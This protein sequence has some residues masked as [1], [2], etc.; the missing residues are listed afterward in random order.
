[1][2]CKSVRKYPS[3]LVSTVKKAIDNISTENITILKQHGLENIVKMG[4]EKVIDN[5]INGNDFFMDDFK[6]NI[7]NEIK[8]V[9][10]KIIEYNE[11]NSDRENI[12][13]LDEK[14]AVDYIAEAQIGMILSRISAAQTGRGSTFAA[15]IKSYIDN[16]SLV[17]KGFPE[18]EEHIHK[19]AGI[20]NST[21]KKV[22]EIGEETEAQLSR[23][24]ERNLIGKYKNTKIPIIKGLSRSLVDMVAQSHN[25]L[26]YLFRTS[27]KK[28]DFIDPK[29][30]KLRKKDAI[31][32]TRI[33]YDNMKKLFSEMDD[34]DIIYFTEKNYP[35]ISRE[36]IVNG[37]EKQKT[38][39]IANIKEASTIEDINS[40]Y[41]KMDMPVF[42]LNKFNNYLNNI[43]SILDTQYKNLFDVMSGS[44]K[45]FS[46]LSDMIR[47]T[48]ILHLNYQKEN[49]EISKQ[50]YL[51][52]ITTVKNKNYYKTKEITHYDYL[53]FDQNLSSKDVI[54][55]FSSLA[56]RREG[57]K[58]SDAIV[59]GRFENLKN[60]SNNLVNYS[61]KIASESAA[62]KTAETLGKYISELDPDD[63][64][65]SDNMKNRLKKLITLQKHANMWV[66]SYLHPKTGFVHD[67]ITLLNNFL[68]PSVL[69][70]RMKTIL[71]QFSQKVQMNIVNPEIMKVARNIDKY[72]EKIKNNFFDGNK[73]LIKNYYNY[74]NTLELTFGEQSY[75]KKI[76]GLFRFPHKASYEQ[77]MDS[78]K[79]LSSKTAD[80][81]LRI[82]GKYAGFSTLEEN[83]RK[84]ASTGL[85][86][87]A[88]NDRLQ[89]LK[90][91]GRQPKT[92]AEFNRVFD[93]AAK[94]TR[95][96]VDHMFFSYKDLD[97]NPK[98]KNAPMRMLTLFKLP[99]IGSAHITSN[100]IK[101]IVGKYD[102]NNGQKRLAFA[103]LA[104]TAL[105][106]LLGLNLS[107]YTPIDFMNY[108]KE[109][110]PDLSSEDSFKEQ[111]NWRIKMNVPH[112]SFF[113]SLFVNKE[114]ESIFKNFVVQNNAIVGQIYS[115]AS[116]FE[117]KNKNYT[118]DK[119]LRTLIAGKPM[120]FNPSYTLSARVQENRHAN[121]LNYLEVGRMVRALS[122]H[123][124]YLHDLLSDFHERY[125]ENLG[126]K[127]IGTS[128]PGFW[129]D[130]RDTGDE[131]DV[132]YQ[133]RNHY[134]EAMTGK[135]NV[136]LTVF[137]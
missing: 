120:L 137:E 89:L 52:K 134:Y 95:N 36:F 78:L 55:N 114:D 65:L 135:D 81:M 10:N 67:S 44:N 16:N 63:G 104:M 60:Y 107:R 40:L 82:G 77:V 105:G 62:F 79:Q 4:P 33:M 23:I 76:T 116:A 46:S 123:K 90:D 124:D 131:I 8:D 85:Y 1:M 98:H 28:S 38:N 74:K 37:L 43:Q 21:R 70:L 50:E 103:S 113:S 130:L 27:G 126:N 106:M 41:Q 15:R 9:N 119:V 31:E 122:D 64:S 22:L 91:Q 56:E 100:M 96:M 59:V 35:G 45:L 118:W 125:G 47:E 86:I 61:D 26:K 83:M 39:I 127:L 132:L 7:S 24:D 117:Y 71:G 133:V 29:L 11:S 101:S 93:Q 6:K 30:S 20:S 87:K 136:P 19:A 54:A 53:S 110:A 80:K 14:V 51:N 48:K 5:I 13:L 94:F 121:Y 12:N 97:Q 99:I 49:G 57:R 84:T 18:I 129:D 75:T 88:I 17:F 69:T 108:L 42:G 111:L 68:V 32:T 102:L 109:M 73:D 128:F 112:Y 115:L 92:K 2:K 72:E 58:E 25:S 34:E 66:E 3:K